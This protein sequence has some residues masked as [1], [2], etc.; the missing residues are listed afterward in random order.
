LNIENGPT[1][2]QI[3]EWKSKFGEVYVATFSPAE[4]YV[5]RPLR[6]LEY[7]QILQLG[8]ADNKTFAEEKV[9]QMCIVWPD[10]DPTKLATL[11]AGTISTVV[12]LVMAASNFGVTEEP[13][14]L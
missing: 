2:E 9:A 3:N 5:Y 1:Q 6:R 12:D 8:Q 14:K 4:K 7:K 11:K 10:I 13:V